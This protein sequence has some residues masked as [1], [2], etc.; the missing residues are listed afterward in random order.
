V[1][2]IAPSQNQPPVAA[3]TSSCTNLACSFDSNGSTDDVG[4]TNR[5]WTFGDG[6]TAG[7]V[8][9]PS[10][11]YTA[12]GSYNVTL[13]VTD[14]GGLSNSITKQVTVTAPP[15][16]PT[17]QPPVARFTSS[18][19][20]HR[21]TLDASTSTDDNGIVSYSWDLDKTPNP[22]ATGK[23]VTVNY[24]HGGTHSVTLTVTDTAGQTN[25]ITIVITAG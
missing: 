15:P 10:H 23:I 8:V 16:P 3:F 21:C 25:S 19:S 7:N 4:I 6:G 5:S 9:S 18:C 11:T 13:T 24:P 20:Q 17:D 2:V 14:G 12:A 22:T 1:S